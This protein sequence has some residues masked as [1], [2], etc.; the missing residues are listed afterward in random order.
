MVAFA[1]PSIVTWVL[2]P[3][4]VFLMILGI[5]YIQAFGPPFGR[6]PSENWREEEIQ[7]E[8][9]KLTRADKVKAPP[10]VEPSESMELELKELEQLKRG[11]EDEDYV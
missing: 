5:S 6:A 1:I 3:V 2:I 9:A 10:T 7:K 4:P 8:M 11:G